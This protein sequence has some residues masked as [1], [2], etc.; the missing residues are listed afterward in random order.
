MSRV[1]VLAPVA[2]AL[3]ACLLLTGWRLGWQHSDDVP[4]GHGAVTPG[5]IDGNRLAALYGDRLVSPRE[6]YLLQRKGLARAG[7]V[8]G[9]LAC[10]GVTLQ[11]DSEAEADAHM[12]RHPDLATG[13]PPCTT[14]TLHPAF[15]RGASR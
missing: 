6:L 15:R 11:F 1:R 14:V 2:L 8:S 10:Q 4:P 7:V 5:G 9:P 13:P 12:A 3:V